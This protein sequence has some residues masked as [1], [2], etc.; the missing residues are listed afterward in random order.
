[1]ASI[2]DR[3]VVWL[4]FACV[5]C[6]WCQ[7][8]AYSLLL[9]LILFCFIYAFLQISNKFDNFLIAHQMRSKPVIKCRTLAFIPKRLKMCEPN[10]YNNFDDISDISHELY[11][12]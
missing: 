5:Q 4:A 7:S 11:A 1:M 10:K 2:Y 12:F 8:S 3:L 6:Q 9:H